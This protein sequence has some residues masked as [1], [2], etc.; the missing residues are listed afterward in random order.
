[1]ARISHA[2]KLDKNSPSIFVD[3][4]SHLLLPIFNK[5]LKSLK[6]NCDFDTEPICSGLLFTCNALRFLPTHIKTF[7][8]NLLYFCYLSFYTLGPIW[9]LYKNNQ[10]WKYN[11]YVHNLHKGRIPQL[12]RVLQGSNQQ[13]VWSLFYLLMAIL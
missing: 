1:M 2:I 5:M 8:W 3:S 7:S 12:G 6:A 9:A 10:T 4:I 13:L 11:Y